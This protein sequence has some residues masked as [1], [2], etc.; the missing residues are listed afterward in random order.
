MKIL[1]DLKNK[2]QSSRNQHNLNKFD[3][4]FDWNVNANISLIEQKDGP[5]SVEPE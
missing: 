2:Y 3:E 5:M 1:N 4:M